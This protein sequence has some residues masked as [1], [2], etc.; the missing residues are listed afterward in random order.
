MFVAVAQAGK[1]CEHNAVLDSDVA[2][3]EGLEEV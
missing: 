1:G 2:D 3:F